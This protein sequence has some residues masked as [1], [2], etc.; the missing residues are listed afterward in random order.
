MSITL[1]KKSMEIERVFSSVPGAITYKS[2]KVDIEAS[3]TPKE[4]IINL[5]V[6]IQCN[7]IP[8]WRRL[9]ED[10]KCL[11]GRSNS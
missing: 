6:T 4:T 3:E 8:W 11:F 2:L 1:G 10:C 5:H 7:Y 9:I